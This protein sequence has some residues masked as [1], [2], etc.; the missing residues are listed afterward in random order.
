MIGVLVL[1][2]IFFVMIV[3]HELAHFFVARLH[4]HLS[5]CPAKWEIGDKTPSGIALKLLNLID[6]KGLDVLA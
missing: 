4:E 6:H 1:L 3:G 5:I 2:L